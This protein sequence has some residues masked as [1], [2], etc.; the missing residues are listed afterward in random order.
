MAMER[1]KGRTS[2]IFVD[3][4][5][6]QHSVIISLDG[7]KWTVGYRKPD[8]LGWHSVR[9]RPWFDTYEEAETDLIEYAQRRKM[10]EITMYEDSGLL[11]KD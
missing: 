10:T 2:R 6:W 9:S 8:R 7:E 11:E 5:G 4:R 3:G 1:E